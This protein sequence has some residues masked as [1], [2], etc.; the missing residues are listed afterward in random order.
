M[1][2]LSPLQKGRCLVF[3]NNFYN[4][5]NTYIFIH[6][7]ITGQVLISVLLGKWFWSYY[8][9][10]Q[11]GKT[12]FDVSDSTLK[13]L[14]QEVVEILKKIVGV[15]VFTKVYN[16]VQKS[17]A[18]RKGDRKRQRA[19]EVYIHNSHKGHSSLCCCNRTYKIST[20]KYL[21]PKS[22]LSHK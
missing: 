6:W 1:K 13:T 18:V 9:F 19:L 3:Y 21:F 8:E 10:L 7:W 12:L 4:V 22:Y 15:E 2:F 11:L 16:E 17:R 14:A 20:L 5:W